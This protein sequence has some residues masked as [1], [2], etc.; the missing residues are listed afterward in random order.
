MHTMA[1]LPRR[2]HVLALPLGSLWLA[3]TWKCGRAACS[4]AASLGV[5]RR[6]LLLPCPVPRHCAWQSLTVSPRPPRPPTPPV[7]PTA[8]DNG[9]LLTLQGSGA[10][11]AAV[12][13]ASV[14]AARRLTSPGV[15]RT[16]SN[17]EG[18]WS[19]DGWGRVCGGAALVRLQR[20]SGLLC[21]CP[22]G[23]YCHSP[24]HPL[25]PSTP[26]AEFASSLPGTPLG[27]APLG[28][29]AAAS[30]DGSP[31]AGSAGDAA[32]KRRLS[33]GLRRLRSALQE[34]AS[35]LSASGSSG[36]GGSGGVGMR[37]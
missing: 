18:E 3:G 24:T 13:C 15:S 29:A 25:T 31:D 11:D 16:V 33:G 4:A 35:A 37:P 20:I 8:V 17:A 10:Y 26:P 27:G 12:H 21:C 5:R 6:V 19:V 34:F 23:S 2:S 9:S 32:G 30:P 22:L 7:L 28:G 36:G 1:S 14:S